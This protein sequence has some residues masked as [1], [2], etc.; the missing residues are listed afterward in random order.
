MGFKSI[1]NSDFAEILLARPTGS[2]T[3]LT[4]FETFDDVRPRV[5]HQPLMDLRDTFTDDLQESV[6]VVP[7]EYLSQVVDDDSAT[8]TAIDVDL[9]DTFTEDLQESVPVVPTEYL[10]QV[11]D[12]VLDNENIQIGPITYKEYCEQLKAKAKGRLDKLLS[13]V[14]GLEQFLEFYHKMKVVTEVE[15]I[16][17]LIVVSGNNFDKVGMLF[18]FLKLQFI[19]PSTYHRCQSHVVVPAIKKL[20]SQQVAENH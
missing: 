8:L 17:E 2:G 14:T 5:I 19:S 3:D 9:G 11:E 13:D 7:T 1:T 10:S 12:D 15:K 16:E 4:A 20:W 6:P 18:N